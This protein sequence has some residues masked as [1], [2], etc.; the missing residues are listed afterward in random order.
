MLMKRVHLHLK[1]ETSTGT[2]THQGTTVHDQPGTV[3][4]VKGRHSLPLA[5][6]TPAA[7]S[8]ADDAL[9]ARQLRHVTST[10]SRFSNK[11]R[12]AAFPVAETRRLPHATAA[13]QPPAG[14]GL[15]QRGSCAGRP[16]GC[17]PPPAAPRRGWPTPWRQ[18]PASCN[19]RWPRQQASPTQPPRGRRARR[20]PAAAGEMGGGG[21]RVRGR[22]HQA[23]GFAQ[24]GG[25][26]SHG[27]SMHHPQMLTRVARRH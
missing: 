16:P 2:P 5:G 1:D 27:A 22:G 25:W 14:C 8:C 20:G 23:R 19:Q 3:E 15:R 6:R 4:G 21:G 7:T 24:G 9:H 11:R 12:S 17:T 10:T 26:S 13:W 18:R